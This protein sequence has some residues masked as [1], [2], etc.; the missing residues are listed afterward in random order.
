MKLKLLILIFAIF[1]LPALVNAVTE[2]DLDVNL[3]SYWD[4]DRDESL[5]KDQV[6]E[7]NNW[8]DNTG[9]SFASGC[10]NN[11]CMN[12]TGQGEHGIYDNSLSGWDSTNDEFTL[13]GWFNPNT[14]ARGAA[15]MFMFGGHA[16]LTMGW[17]YE[18]PLC[19]DTTSALLSSTGSSWDIANEDCG[20]TMTVD[21]DIWYHFVFGYNGTHY[22]GYLNGSLI[23]SL[24]TATQVIDLTGLHFGDWPAGN[25]ADAYWDGPMDE[26]AFWNRGLN[27]QE[28][29]FLY[30]NGNG[31][32]ASGGTFVTSD[33][34]PPE[35]LSYNLSTPSG[36]CTNWNTDKSNPCSTGDTTPTV[37]ITT[38][39]DAFCAIG[40][41]DKNFSY[42]D[43]LPDNR[44]C[45]NG[46]TK[47]LICTLRAPDELFYEDS[48]IYIGC[49]NTDDYENSTSTSGALSLQITG[50]ESGTDA[51]IGVG[52]Q[53][54]LLS[55]YT[56][57]TN[58]QIYAR[59]LDGTQDTG[60]FDWVAKK[61]TKVWAFNHIT[62]GEQYVGLFNLTPVLYVLEMANN[63]NSTIISTVEAFIN[64]NP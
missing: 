6:N 36:D 62:K 3:T 33:S 12:I 44:S 57:Y 4:L 54:A 9:T 55:G 35:I 17:K 42:Y 27:R 41:E 51:A 63:T 34:T 26:I 7:N 29:E 37:M 49:R 47:S 39:D 30:N 14:A 50:L 61:G 53:N 19:A 25:S 22:F 13:S 52:V 60:T 11:G 1:L 18:D 58:Q 43:G 46:G 10:F 28:V 23:Y 8:T 20:N 2:A 40:L 56:N 32:F 59:K 5:P 24:E 48:T 15:G 31:R 64:S 21:D 45:E 16:D 38:D